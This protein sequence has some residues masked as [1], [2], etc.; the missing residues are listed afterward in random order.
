MALGFGL[1]FGGLLPQRLS[2]LD[3]STSVHKVG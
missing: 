1:S 2:S 3:R